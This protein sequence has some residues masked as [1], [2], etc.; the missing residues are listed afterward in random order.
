VSRPFRPKRHGFGWEPA[1]ATGWAI[2]FAFV[3]VCCIPFLVP[4]WAYAP[5][6][7]IGFM[8]YVICLTA[9]FLV[10]VSRLSSKDE[11]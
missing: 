6:G 9:L 5:W 11:G 8:G 3:A 7:M 2:T 1:N 10:L 4:G